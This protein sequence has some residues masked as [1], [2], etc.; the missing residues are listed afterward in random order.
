MSYP[1]IVLAGSFHP[2]PFFILDEVDAALDN[3]NVTKVSNYIRYCQHHITSFGLPAQ[4]T[5]VVQRKMPRGNGAVTVHC[6]LTEGHVLHESGRI[7]WRLQGSGIV[8]D[9]T[10]WRLLHALTLEP[11]RP[12]CLLES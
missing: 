10:P 7:G 3:E 12:P 4:A 2:A 5:I 1:G 9:L 11:C 8:I 6:Y